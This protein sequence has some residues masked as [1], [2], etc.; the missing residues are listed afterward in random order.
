MDD[1]KLDNELKYYEKLFEFQSAKNTTINDIENF[2]KLKEIKKDREKNKAELLH[3]EIIE[4]DENNEYD[5]YTSNFR[6]F[7][8]YIYYYCYSFWFIN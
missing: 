3:N 4:Y 2:T 6:L 8:N 7:I 5:I 1:E